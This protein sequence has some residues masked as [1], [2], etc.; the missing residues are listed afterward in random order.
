MPQILFCDIHFG[1]V[2]LQIHSQD[3]L[4][5]KIFSFEIYFVPLQAIM[6]I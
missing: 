1:I 6:I 5:Q 4:C 2:E 3:L